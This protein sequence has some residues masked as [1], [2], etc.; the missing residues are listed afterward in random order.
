[1]KKRAYCFLSVALLTVLCTVLLAGCVKD[2]EPA[3]TGE[4]TQPTG[5]EPEG[6][7]CD[8]VVQ[9]YDQHDELQQFTF[10]LADYPGIE[11][12]VNRGRLYALENGEER[13]IFGEASSP[14]G[15]FLADLN[16]DGI[17][18]FCWTSYFAN[19]AD[20]MLLVYDSTVN[21]YYCLQEPNGF[22]YFVRVEE[23]ELAVYR[24]PTKKQWLGDS[25]FTP[26][27]GD[28]RGHVELKDGQL[29]FTAGDTVVQGE[30]VSPRFDEEILAEMIADISS[31]MFADREYS[32]T[33]LI[34]S[35]DYLLEFMERSQIDF[36]DGVTVSGHWI[37]VNFDWIDDNLQTMIYMEVLEYVTTRELPY[38]AMNRYLYRDP[39][40]PAQLIICTEGRDLGYLQPEDYFAAVAAGECEHHEDTFVIRLDRC[41]IYRYGSEENLFEKLCG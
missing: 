20:R 23:D 26:A 25:V 13:Q 9:I 24:T 32:Q 22:D 5:T 3:G 8:P 31:Y 14:R 34:V 12:A 38:Y 2:Q 40:D 18:D 39:D 17:R 4:S 36:S 10:R 33:T 35:N 30:C 11:F 19:H 6:M 21:Q 7:F 16:G 27:K 28:Q 29:I 15:V 41:A 1:M 37:E